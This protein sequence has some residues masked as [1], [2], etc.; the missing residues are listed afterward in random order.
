MD[1]SQTAPKTKAGPPP[2]S[3][4]PPGL[5]LLQ[6][7]LWR[8][9]GIMWIGGVILVLP[10]LW[11]LATEQPFW[12]LGPFEGNWKVGM[13]LA[14][15][16]TLVLAWAFTALF[17]VLSNAAAGA[18]K[19]YGTLTIM[20]VVTDVTRDTGFLIQGKRHFGSLDTAQ[21][22]R[23]V[24]ARLRGIIL[25]TGAALWFIVGFGVAVLL[26][27]RGFVT[28]SGIWLMTLGPTGLMLLVG[29]L[30]LALQHMRVRGA[31]Q[32]WEEE[33]GEDRTV[34]E[35]ASWTERLDQAGDHVALGGGPKEESG[36]FRMGAV[37][38]IV[39]FLAM[40]I[41]T[42]T[43]AITAAIGPILAERAVPQFL[44]VQEMAG[45]AEVLRRYRMEPEEGVTPARAGAALQNIAFVGYGADPETWERG[46]E[47]NYE[48]GWFP[49]PDFFP[50][51][52]SETVAGDLMSRPF[53]SF[54]EDERAALRQA[55]DHPAH[56]EFHT[57]ARAQLVD[58]VR[59]RWT[60]PFPDTLTFQSLPWP[61]FAAFRTAGLAQVAKATV[62]L[63][64]GQRAQAETTLREL[65]SSG[66]LLADQGPT[67]IDNLMGVVLVN[68]GG[69]AMESLLSRTGR[70][71]DAEAMRWAREGAA[72]AASKARAGLVA[73]DIHSLLQ[74]I[75]NLVE[76]EG[77]LRGLRWEYFATFNMLAPCIN[78]HKMVFG[79]DETYSE[80]RLRARD[81]LVRVRGER[82]LFELAEGNAVG[83]EENRSLE[84]F[85]PR[86][87]SLTLGSSGSPG[88]CASLIASLD[89][90]GN[91]Q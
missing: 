2:L 31:R 89:A 67:L 30:I 74:G 37:G 3:W 1:N 18:E 83:D 79:P 39:L 64:E 55:A 43:V 25:L 91:V 70:T 46:P 24:R 5:E 85:L 35:A 59:G 38:V 60:L 48:E 7:K 10:L 20:E 80:W 61:R 13:A 75:P 66:F 44:S 57:L 22:G 63:A 27:A 77:A 69:D 42:A 56:E 47:T 81:A 9:M 21:R 82:D 73:E 86:F 49:D 41:P 71:A 62:E 8:V 88:S 6:G 68:M 32:E 53:N 23:I 40:L 34:A 4:P 51:P 15:L 12:S 58:V 84:G 76:Q 72:D 90:G 19:G 29:F 78:L 11:A 87:L 50:D 16:G 14:G 45:A 33:E 28:P 65:I 52:F 54:S 17:G 36:K 26:A